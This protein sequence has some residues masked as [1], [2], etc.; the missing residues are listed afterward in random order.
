M[1]EHC[2]C[3]CRDDIARGSPLPHGARERRVGVV[4]PGWDYSTCWQSSKTRPAVDGPFSPPS[5][6]R[7]GSADRDDCDASAAGDFV[8]GG[9]FAQDSGPPSGA[10]YNDAGKSAAPRPSARGEVASC[11][12]QSEAFRELTGLF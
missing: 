6:S 1:V 5:G 4:M 2:S 12:A 3:Y 10:K 11:P 7:S 9:F 8:A